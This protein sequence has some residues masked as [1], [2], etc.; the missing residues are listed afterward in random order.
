M[1]K[2]LEN[3]WNEYLL[4]KCAIIDTYEE[5]SLTKKAAEL[6]QKANSLLDKEQKDAVDK[7][8]DELCNIEALFA[9]KAF[10]K[11]C[12]FAVSFIFEAGSFEK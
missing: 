7:Y 5:K 10:L 12:E 1:K 3:L 11:G 6:H 4:D 2:I 8:I 9:K